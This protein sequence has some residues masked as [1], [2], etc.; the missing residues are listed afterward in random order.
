MKKSELKNMIKECVKEV[1]FEEGVLSGIISEVV[2]G[3]G[4]G[5]LLQ[6][7]K[8]PQATAVSSPG[9]QDQ[10]RK[11][12]N[13]VGGDAYQAIKKKFKNPGIFEG[14]Q[15]LRES[16]GK[17]ALSGVSPN[18]P[19]IDLSQIPGLGNWAAVAVRKR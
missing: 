8:A 1:I 16:S 15:P 7:T 5:G 12:L 11:V 3:I 17:G 2:Q 9:Y 10:R 19:G 18:D 14:T 6:E 4:G 13:A